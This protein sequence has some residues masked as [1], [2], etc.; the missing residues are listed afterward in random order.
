[1]VI[2]FKKN[3]NLFIFQFIFRYLVIYDTQ[4]KWA[5]DNN[6]QPQHFGHYNHLSYKDSI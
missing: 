2:Y 6:G 3:F 5:Y 4:N 1:M